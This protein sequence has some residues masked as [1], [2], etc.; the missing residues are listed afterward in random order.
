MS[1]TGSIYAAAIAT[2]P[3]LAPDTRFL[4]SPILPLLEM[5][6]RALIQALEFTKGDRLMA[7]V[8]LGIARTTPYRQL[9]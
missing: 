9:K 4:D 8:L 7:A 2:G 5:E 1:A 3:S 6:R